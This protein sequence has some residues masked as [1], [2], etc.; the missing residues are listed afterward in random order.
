M[1]E[2]KQFGEQLPHLITPVPGPESVRLCQESIVSEPTS[3]TRFTP[4]AAPVFWSAAAGANV[5]DVD[6][7]TYIDCTCGFGVS[8]IGH[9]CEAVCQAMARQSHELIHAMGD[10]CP[11]TPRVR[12]ARRLSTI[13]GRR[14]ETQV[15]FA[16]TGSE[17]VEIAL[18]AALLHTGKPGVIAFQYAFHGQTIG[19]LSITGHDD[20]RSPFT[21]YLSPH[22]RHIPFP[23]PYRED[24]QNPCFL[25]GDSCLT[26]IEDEVARSRGTS[27][28]IGVVIVEPIQGCAGNLIPKDS[29]LRGL[30]AICSNNDVLLIADE[31]FT[32]LGR[33]GAWLALDHA[34][35]IADITCVGKILGG[36]VPISA[37]IAPRDVFSSFTSDSFLALHGSTFAG[38]PLACSCAL[39]VLDEMERR[40][41]VGHAQRMGRLLL[42]GLR[43]LKAKHPLVGDVRGRGLLAAIELVSDPVSKLPASAQA[44]SVVTRALRRGVILLL[45]RIPYA[46]ALGLTPSFAMTE[47][48][49]N[50]VLSVLDECLSE[51]GN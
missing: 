27:S 11:S 49:M 38:D 25:S 33:T 26:L 34:G 1:A 13:L 45:T 44:A 50:Y 12:L 43:E 51:V 48:Q 3:V 21:P 30:S 36:G 35:V 28:E 15:L 16:T 46:N 18:K 42:E 32:G 39:A 40:D 4:N 8:A 19:T 47:D 6:G 20:L 23:Y 7:N 41:L 31:V 37:C 5:L 24:D 14:H 10:V 9:S 2:T 29:F 22:V 17:C